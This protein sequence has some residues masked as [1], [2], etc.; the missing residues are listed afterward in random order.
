MATGNQRPQLITVDTNVL[1]DLAAD[2]QIVC[3]CI[4]TV[5][6]RLHTAQ[7]VVTPTVIQELADLF[8]HG[9]TVQRRLAAKVT[10]SILEWAFQPVKY[11]P[12]GHGIVEQIGRKLR[13]RTD[14]S[15]R[16]KRFFRYC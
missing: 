13:D 4:E 11:V 16:G 5:R 3:A 1:L 6:A 8:D 14:S 9:S 7:F 15:I 2:N 12:V 10:R